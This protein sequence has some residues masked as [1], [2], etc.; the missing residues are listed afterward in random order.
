M[1]DYLLIN[2]AEMYRDAEFVI[3]NLSTWSCFCHLQQGFINLRLIHIP[4]QYSLSQIITK[5]LLIRFYTKKRSLT[6][7]PHQS[8]EDT[9]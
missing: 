8:W 4:N 3:L 7:L 1:I 5:Q 2:T 9:H 6:N